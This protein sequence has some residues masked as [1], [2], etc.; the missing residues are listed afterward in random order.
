MVLNSNKLKQLLQLI[1]NDLKLQDKN[2]QLKTEIKYNWN[3]IEIPLYN[4]G[5]LVRTLYIFLRFVCAK[6]SLRRKLYT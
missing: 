2:T 4:K 6:K 3:R 5:F 1:N